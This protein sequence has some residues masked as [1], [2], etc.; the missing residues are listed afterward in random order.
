[1]AVVASQTVSVVLSDRQPAGQNTDSPYLDMA[2]VI[3]FRCHVVH[4]PLN[5]SK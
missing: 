2:A 3:M 4:P 5:A 1:M